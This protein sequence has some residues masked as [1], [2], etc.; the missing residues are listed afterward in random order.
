MSVTHGTGFGHL[1]DH[2]RIPRLAAGFAE[3]EACGLRPE[4][5]QSP[6]WPGV[7][8]ATPGDGCTYFTSTSLWPET[9]P[10]GAATRTKYEPVA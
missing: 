5:R 7:N 2:T 1:F 9:P 3:Y 4:L 10:S 8:P 6:G